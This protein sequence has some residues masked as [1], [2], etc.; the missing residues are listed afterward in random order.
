MKVNLTFGNQ[1]FTIEIPEDWTIA[2][3]EAYLAELRDYYS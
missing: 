3:I 1:G 2:R